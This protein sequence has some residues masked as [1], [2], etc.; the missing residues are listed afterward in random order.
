MISSTGIV[1]SFTVTS[2]VAAFPAYSVLTV[3][4][5]VP[6]LTAVTTPSST[7]A[8]ELSL[9]LQATFL[10]VA[11]SGV[12]VAVRVTIF[13]TTISQEVI[14]KVTV[15]TG[16]VRTSTVTSHVAVFP[17]ST[18]VAVIVAF[19]A[20]TAVTKPYSFTS[21]TELSLLSQVTF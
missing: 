20:L 4:V 7:V 14:S 9:L 8:T 11:L 3:I 12:T 17:P 16:I 13:P 19:P 2:H 1:F 15:A 5:A 10:F 6:G 21:A 18:V